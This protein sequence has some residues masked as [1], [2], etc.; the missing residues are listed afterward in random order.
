METPE[1]M[2]YGRWLIA[3]GKQPKRRAD[4]DQK[5]GS[6]DL[7]WF[8]APAIG[9]KPF[10]ISSLASLPSAIGYQLWPFR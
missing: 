8:S 6:K 4:I 10:A 1:L 2:A 7:I 3:D 5:F 9:H